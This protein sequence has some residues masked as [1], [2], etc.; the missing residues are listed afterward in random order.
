[1]LTN[2]WPLQK[3]GA[4]SFKRLLGRW[5]SWYLASG[6]N[7]TINEPIGLVDECSLFIRE[8]VNRDAPEI[9]KRCPER[10]PFVGRGHDQWPTRQQMPQRA[11]SSAIAQL[12]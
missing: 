6:P 2:R 8:F 11:K 3:S 7:R 4:A 10:M 1:M 5:P 12:V 9:A